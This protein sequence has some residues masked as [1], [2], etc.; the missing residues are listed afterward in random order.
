MTSFMSR[1]G[2]KRKTRSFGGM[3]L[4]NVELKMLVQSNFLTNMGQ[5]R[6]FLA[7]NFEV[8]REKSKYCSG[9]I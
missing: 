8:I 4:S 2:C 9:V 6:L 7:N 3:S 5:D 1:T